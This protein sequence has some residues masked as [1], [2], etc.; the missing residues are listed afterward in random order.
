M[1]IDITPFS[2]FNLF[3]AW[4][5]NVIKSKVDGYDVSMG[6]DEVHLKFGKLTEEE[7]SF[8]ER[9]IRK[10]Q[11]IPKGIGFDNDDTI[12]TFACY[13][14]K[15][16]KKAIIKYPSVTYYWLRFPEMIKAAFQ[17]E[18]GHIVN[19]DITYKSEHGEAY[20]QEHHQCINVSQD[21]RINQNLNYQTL[22]YINRC[23]F[24]FTNSVTKLN[25]PEQYFPKC[26]LNVHAY[27]GR[28]TANFIH[29][30]YHNMHPKPQPTKD[31]MVLK[32][33]SYVKTLVDKYGYPK[34][35][36]GR[37]VGKTP[38]SNDVFDYTIV[39]ITDEEIVA[40][41]KEDYMFFEQFND[42]AQN[43]MGNYIFPEKFIK[44][45]LIGSY[46]Y[47]E[48]VEELEVLQRPVSSKI[49]P[50]VGSIALSIKKIGS[51][52]EANYSIISKVIDE[53]K[54]K[55]VLNEFTD[56]LQKIIGAGDADTYFEKLRIGKDLF[57]GNSEEGIFKIDFVI[58]PLSP[59]PKNPPPPPPPDTKNVDK[60][61]EGDVVQIKKG[62]KKGKYGVIQKITE[63]GEYV[64]TEVSEEV[65]KAMV[66][67]KGI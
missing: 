49:K 64:I 10:I 60:P 14:D 27:K 18:I 36:Y 34:D 58:F 9:M 28:A 1:I 17:H 65:A 48:D 5:M 6:S 13:W 53:E 59:N 22:D 54:G 38:I 66:A 55:C 42:P 31:E 25:V 43:I 21:V 63:D 47:N 61:K 4:Y 2:D 30:N 32:I 46:K 12:G 16:K 40:L 3:F 8:T 11:L 51:I 67:K 35:T 56:E 23:L 19:G 52:S 41:D 15:Q 26:G 33:G 24:T 57:N 50:E 7:R 39:K 62:D 45:N 29:K 20:Q 44:D 37:I